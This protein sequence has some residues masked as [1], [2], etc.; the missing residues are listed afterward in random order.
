MDRHVIIDEDQD[1]PQ[2]TVIEVTDSDF[3]SIVDAISGC[4]VGD[5]VFTIDDAIKARTTRMLLN[6]QYSE[7]TAFIFDKWMIE[8]S[9]LTVLQQGY[10]YSEHRDA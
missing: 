2:T 6:L 4:M 3:E 8:T 10:K 7:H 9:L 5:D 1:V